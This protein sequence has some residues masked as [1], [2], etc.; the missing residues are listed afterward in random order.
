[1][2]QL[3]SQLRQGVALFKRRMEWLTTESRRLFGVI[4][5]SVVIIV[6]DIKTMSPQQFDQYRC[7]LE[8]VLKE[9]VSMLAKFNLYRYALNY[10]RWSLPWNRIT[11]TY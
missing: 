6:L 2:V 1:M 8:R 3:A 7:A 5:E 10:H 9:Q 4:Q 11:I